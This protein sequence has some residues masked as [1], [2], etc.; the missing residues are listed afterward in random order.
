MSGAKPFL[1]VPMKSV[2]NYFTSVYFIEHEMAYVKLR[3]EKLFQDMIWVQ[4][5]SSLCAL[6]VVSHSD[7]ESVSFIS[8]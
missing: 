7:V 6:F 2:G 8:C 5:L 3:R 1:F 4:S